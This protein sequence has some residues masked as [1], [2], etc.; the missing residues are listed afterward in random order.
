MRSRLEGGRCP[1]RK[2]GSQAL[3]GGCAWKHQVAS[4]PPF[5]RAPLNLPH[6]FVQAKPGLS[7]VSFLIS[8]KRGPNLGHPPARRHPSASP[9]L[10]SAL[11]GEQSSPQRT[12][13]PLSQSLPDFLWGKSRAVFGEDS[14]ALLIQD[15]LEGPLPSFSLDEKVA[16]TGGAG[17]SRVGRLPSSPSPGVPGVPHSYYSL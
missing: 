9:P 8:R 3:V 2:G 15:S 4:N 11:Q 7:V 17:Q 12:C 10:I 1:S 14:L 5:I 16:E 13:F 6:L